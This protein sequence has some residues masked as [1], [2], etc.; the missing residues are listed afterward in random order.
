MMEAILEAQVRSLMRDLTAE[1]HMAM[2]DWFLEQP[3]PVTIEACLAK[4][5]EIL[6]EK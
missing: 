1:Q 2:R 4:G 3:Q 5:R 6:G